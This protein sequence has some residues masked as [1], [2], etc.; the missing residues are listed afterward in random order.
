MLDTSL[1]TYLTA[2]KPQLF[3][4]QALNC[5]CFIPLWSGDHVSTYKGVKHIDGGFS[6]N[7]PVFDEHTIRVCC[8]SGPSDISP[9]DRAKMELLSGTV[10]NTPIYL[11]FA[12]CRRFRKALFPPPA[13]YIVDLLE[14]GFHDTKDFIL[15]NDLIQCNSCYGSSDLHAL[16]IFAKP[17]P[18]L[19]PSASPALSR[20]GSVQPRA[21]PAPEQRP[22]A[23]ATP[24]AFSTQLQERLDRVGSP[25]SA[26][27]QC[28]P[29]RSQSLS[30]VRSLPVAPPEIVVED[31]DKTE[32]SAIESD[33]SWSETARQPAN[34]FKPL[35]RRNTQ[36]QLLGDSSLLE[37][38]F[39]L[40]PDPLPSCPP[41]PNLNR[42]CTECIRLRQEARLDLLEDRIRTEVDK[43]RRL[44]RAPEASKLGSVL[45]SP[46]RWMRRFATKSSYELRPSARDVIY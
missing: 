11:N 15:T 13:D 2:N 21:K 26:L 8:F 36:S 22:R 34:K 12:N 17:G 32:D 39:T 45:M 29:E 5:S 41:S 40:A 24:R 44:G 4:P 7:L 10:L 28:E 35:L 1:V 27:G 20:A 19:T 43:Y 30:S 37:A 42:H 46:I 38:K 6:D 25:D 14:R 33:S 23:P 16:P 18:T 31:V 3:R 9:Y